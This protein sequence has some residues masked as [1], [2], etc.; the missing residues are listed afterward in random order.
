IPW[1]DVNLSRWNSTDLLRYKSKS[2]N[3]ND[4]LVTI[5]EEL[6]TLIIRIPV[7]T[8]INDSWWKQ[9]SYLI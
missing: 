4:N 8:A 3:Y 1:E 2:K 6:P 9:T 7:A 5:P